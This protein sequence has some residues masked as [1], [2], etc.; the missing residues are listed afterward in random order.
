VA[1]AVFDYALWGVLF[2][3]LAAVP[4]PVAQMFFDI[5][6]GSL[7]DNSDCSVVKDVKVRST[8]LDYATAHLASLAGYPLPTGSTTPTPSGSVGRVSSASEGA[9]SASMGY[10][11]VRESQA[12]WVQTQYGA[13][14]WQFTRAFRT[15][16]F[17]ARPPYNFGPG[18][19]G[20]WFPL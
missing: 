9:V 18:A 11:Q 8:L 10:G 12:W 6:A 3:E 14:F 1:V 20:G 19:Y 17:S 15:F 4:E 13:S 2:P 5:A 7:V 16:R